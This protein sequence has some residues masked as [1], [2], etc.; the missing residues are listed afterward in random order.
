[1]AKRVIWSNLASNEKYD[2]FNYW[3]SR[4]K[5]KAYS[6]KLNVLF[7]EAIQL[8]KDFPTIGR[9]TDISNVRRFVVRDYLILY[10][11]AAD[12][13]YILSIWDTRQDPDKLTARLG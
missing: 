10:K 5:S 8:I 12:A 1:M 4:N 7:N 13:I 3:N 6:K 11:V 9:L 2:I